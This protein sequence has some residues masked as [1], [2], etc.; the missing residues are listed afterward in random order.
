MAHARLETLREDFAKIIDI[1]SVLSL[2]HWDLEVFMPPKAASA[3]GQQLAT[4]SGIAHRMLTDA[5][6]GEALAELKAESLS[7]DDALT[8]REIDHDYA[9]ATKLPE[10]YVITFAE[11]QNLAY[12]AWIEAREN[13]DFGLFQPHL[14][15]LVDLLRQK[16]DF[17]GYE[18]TPYNAL[19]SEYERGMTAEQIK[20]IFTDLAD[21][22]SV[23]IEKIMGSSDQPNVEWTDQL[24]DEGAQWDFTL[25]VL[26]DMGYD[27]DAGRQDKSIHP[28]TTNFDVN[29][30]RITTRVH[31]R[32]LFSALTGSIHE[33]GHALYEQGFLPGDQRTILG[34]AASLGI[35]ESQSRMWENMIGRSLPFWKHYESSIKD[36]YP[37]QLE[38]VSANDLYRA[39]NEVKPSLIRVEADECT[40]N[41]HIIL[42]FEIEL[43]LIEGDLKVGDL[44]EIWNEK[45]KD[46]LGLDVPSDAEGC[47]QDIHWSHGS[48]GYFPT[49]ALG[50][51]YAAQLFEKI[52]AD[53]PQLWADVEAGNFQGLL[54]WLRKHVHE[55][56]RRKLASEIVEDASGSAPTAEPYMRYL[57]SK[58]GDLYKL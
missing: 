27:F 42:R 9:L 21:R 13:S 46:Y 17:L 15:T 50:N 47:L 53:L 55:V 31:E 14:A 32:E 16:A 23:L 28:F 4:M 25:E 48:M 1:H 35:H 33:G 22:Q 34:Q 38:K 36:R 11:K 57:E 52:E 49:Y 5:S 45:M 24:W 7:G 56:G 58:Y 44:P 10:S 54:N 41:L 2:M 20:P 43:A 26:R 6:I 30:V 19:L 18:G 51:L 3:R 8:V 37:G 39:I 12:Q 40:Y 29:D